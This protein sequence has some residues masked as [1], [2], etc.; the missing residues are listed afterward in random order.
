MAVLDGSEIIEQFAFAQVEIDGEVHADL[1][2]P[3]L[4]VITDEWKV[5]NLV[6]SI[7]KDGNLKWQVKNL[8]NG[9]KKLIEMKRNLA[10]KTTLVDHIAL[11]DGLATVSIFI[12][13]VTKDMPVPVPGFFT[14][15]G[16]I[17]IYVRMLDENKITTVGEVP[18]ETIKLIGD[19][20]FKQD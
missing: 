9:F 19:S 2:K 20:V 11:S 17:N 6:T 7:F 3:D 4:S 12:E 10:E 16:A 18:L 8:P 15:R 1:L 14:S 13:P 5:N